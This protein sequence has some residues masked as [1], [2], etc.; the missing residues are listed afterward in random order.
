MR[1]C[2]EVARRLR[3]CVRERDLVARPGG[4][5]FIVVLTDVGG[6]SGAVRDSV[7]R[8]R[9]TLAEPFAVEG[10][11]MELRAAIGVASRPEDGADSATLLGVADRR[12]YADKSARN[13]SLR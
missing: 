7:D 13:G 1:R 5:E 10:T 12:M 4:D 6:F 3:A 9:E 8:I 11:G 2:A